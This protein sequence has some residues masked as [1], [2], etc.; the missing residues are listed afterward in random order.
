MILINAIYFKGEWEKKFD[1]RKT[2][3]KIFLIIKQKKN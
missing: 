2:E 3:K 1:K